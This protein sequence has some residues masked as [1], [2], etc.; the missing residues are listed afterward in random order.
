[1]ALTVLPTSA[2]KASSFLAETFVYTGGNDTG[3][4]YYGNGGT[5]TLNLGIIPDEIRS[6]NGAPLAD[7]NPA[8]RKGLPTLNQAVYHGSSFDYLRLTNGREI[9]FQGIEYLMFT[10]GV[11]LELQ[12]HPNDRLF[13]NQW[14]LA[15]LE[16]EYILNVLESQ[17]GLRSDAAAI[18]G[19]D[20]RT[21]YRKLKEY[22]LSDLSTDSPEA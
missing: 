11:T 21:L 17:H 9:Y 20:R 15:R 8:T 5:D 18:L 3:T 12:A 7:Y 2:K 22:G 1:M 4:V 16:R 14:N 10:G 13:P 19:I 6:L